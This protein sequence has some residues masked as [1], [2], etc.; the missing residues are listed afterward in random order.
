MLV[1]KKEMNFQTNEVYLDT[2]IIFKFLMDYDIILK[3][4][5]VIRIEESY[6]VF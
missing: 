4:E 1:Q 6:F 3:S 5:T 2:N